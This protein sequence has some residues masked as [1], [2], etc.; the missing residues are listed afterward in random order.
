MWRTNLKILALTLGV[1]AFYTMIAN[2]I[3]QQMTV[4]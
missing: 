3:P 2:V 1:L 4:T